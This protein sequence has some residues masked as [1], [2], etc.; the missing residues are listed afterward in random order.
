MVKLLSRIVAP[1]DDG[2]GCLQEVDRT[3]GITSDPLTQFACIFAAL[4]HDV[5][6]SGVPNAQL[7]KEK[8]PL[9]GKYYNTSIAEQNSVDMAW[10][11]FMDSK[12]D[13]FRGTLC[14][15]ETD[16]KRFRQLVVNA[17]M[18]TDIVDKGL[19]DARNARYVLRRVLRCLVAGLC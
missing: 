5:D 10:E 17:V 3:Y 8:G 15:C 6:H 14:S 2:E 18:A 13:E 19:K 4:I 1:E 12:Y 7:A 16:M 9:A 11:F